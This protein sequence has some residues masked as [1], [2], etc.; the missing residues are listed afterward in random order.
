MNKKNRNT[1]PIDPTISSKNT[2]SFNGTTSSGVFNF[3]SFTLTT[4]E[5]QLLQKGLSFCPSSLKINKAEFLIDLFNFS[6]NVRL[7]KFY[8][9]TEK[10]LSSDKDH[11]PDPLFLFRNES[12]FDPLL[13][14]KYLTTYLQ[15][16]KEDLENLCKK[17]M[18]SFDNLT[19]DE[20]K[21]FNSLRQKVINKEIT[22]SLADKGGGIV[23]TDYEVY[24][25]KGDNFF[26]EYEDS[27]KMIDQ[28][29]D[30]I[31]KDI[32]NSRKK[33]VSKLIQ[34]GVIT[35]KHRKFINSNL[36]PKLTGIKFFMKVHK[37]L[38]L[39]TIPV[40][41]VHPSLGSPNHQ[42]SLLLD[43]LLKPLVTSSNIPSFLQDTNQLLLYARSLS[44][45]PPN[46]VVITSDVSS[47]YTNIPHN[48]GINVLITFLIKTSKFDKE[49]IEAIAT[50]VKHVVSLNY[51]KWQGKI[52]QQIRGVAMGTPLA[53]NYANIFMSAIDNLII[54]KSPFLIK[55]YRYIDDNLFL[56]PKES[57][58][59]LIENTKISEF[60]TISY[61][62]D[63]DTKLEG[64]PFLDTLIYVK[65]GS[66]I[67]TL[68]TK[69]TDKHL[70]LHPSSYHPRHV[71]RSIP[72]SIISRIKRI[73][74]FENDYI[75]NRDQAITWLKNRGYT[76]KEINRA[77]N[78]VD[79]T[80]ALE[81]IQKIENRR[82][83]TQS[84]KGTSQQLTI[85][86]VLTYN[87][88]FKAAPFVLYKHRDT[89]AASLSTSHRTLV[90]FRRTK[91]LTDLLV[92][93][94]YNKHFNNMD[95]TNKGLT[96]DTNGFFRCNKKLPYRSKTCICG[97]MHVEGCRV[98]AHSV[99]RLSH[100][101]NSTLRILSNQSATCE[102]PNV[103]YAIWCRICLK[104]YVGETRQKLSARFDQHLRAIRQSKTTELIYEHFKAHKAKNAF[105]TPI[106]VV[107]TGG[108]KMLQLRESKWISALQ[109]LSPKGLN[110]QFDLDQKY[111]KNYTNMRT[112]SSTPTPSRARAILTPP[113]TPVLNA[114]SSF[115]NTNNTS[116]NNKKR[117]S[118]LFATHS[119]KKIRRNISPRSPN[120][121]T[122]RISFST[123]PIFSTVSKETMN[124]KPEPVVVISPF[125]SPYRKK[126]NLSSN[127][128][129]ARSFHKSPYQM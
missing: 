11:I 46:T 40:R 45:L 70:Y 66:L 63:I 109:S 32:I 26:K 54:E 43:A 72:Y 123:L 96:L 56:L 122:P 20:R 65:N 22:F 129:L 47:L 73:C 68:Y 125:S 62:W 4:G 71:I 102:T 14:C 113:R 6:R 120:T 61:T 115:S 110:T 94:S 126:T 80:T 78:K 28:E 93:P 99:D 114:S 121:I 31:L 30:K 111:K 64:T 13:N 107:K 38:N 128:K 106:E 105:I 98:C 124:N 53:V 42:L 3:S 36:K 17:S 85:P 39:S 67:T 97:E 116:K 108:N 86:L 83:K 103:I 12:S 33:V 34:T 60:P 23:L 117:W 55:H 8:E 100:L 1:K 2:E 35:N 89:L 77:K 57:I 119:P 51:L 127:R 18:K 90:A 19:N 81:H 91:N 29:E 75:D 10:T 9:N 104:I 118:S 48:L 69:D 87:T 74:S 76:D 5:N 21:G 59:L 41:P 92:H 16:I 24:K 84:N 44:N 58:N 50:A 27:Y 95:N 15:D 82:Y 49:Q 79:K 37:S 88:K 7:K 52:F 101:P 25:N 112:I